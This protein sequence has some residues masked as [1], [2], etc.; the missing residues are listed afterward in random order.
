MLIEISVRDILNELIKPS[1]NRGLAIIVD[2]VT[3]KLLISDKKFR[4]F[5]PPQNWK[6]TPKLRQI[7][8]Y[9]L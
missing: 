6:I 3:Q 2:F 9:K 5:I 8:R 4:S 7:F 1:N